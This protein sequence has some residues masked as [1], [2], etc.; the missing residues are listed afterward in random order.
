MDHRDKQAQRKGPIAG[1]GAIGPTV[2]EG[3]KGIEKNN[4][5]LPGRRRKPDRV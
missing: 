2:E 5:T 4:S 3:E 1:G